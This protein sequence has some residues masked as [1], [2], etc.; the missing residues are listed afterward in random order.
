MTLVDKKRSL[1]G[2]NIHRDFRNSPW[3]PLTAL[4]LGREEGECKFLLRSEINRLCDMVLQ[5]NLLAL[6]PSLHQSSPTGSPS[7]LQCISNHLRNHAI[8]SPE[9][10]GTDGRRCF[11]PNCSHIASSDADLH[12]K[13]LKI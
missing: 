7:Q 3:K 4:T 11:W 12:S 6:R 5:K 10:N 1:S 8:S 9:P 2:M 13:K